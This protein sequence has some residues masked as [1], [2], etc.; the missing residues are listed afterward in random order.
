MA[1][2]LIS[3]LMRRC[4]RGFAIPLS[5]L[6]EQFGA[7]GTFSRFKF[8]IQGHRSHNDLPSFDRS[9]EF[10]AK[11][12]TLDV[13]RRTAGK[14][15][16]GMTSRFKAAA[17]TPTQPDQPLPMPLVNVLADGSLKR[18]AIITPIGSISAFPMSR[19]CAAPNGRVTVLLAYGRHNRANQEARR[20]TIPLKPRRMLKRMSE[21]FGADFRGARLRAGMTHAERTKRARVGRTY[22][23][24][25]APG[26]PRPPRIGLPSLGGIALSMAGLSTSDIRRRQRFGQGTRGGQCGWRALESSASR[27]RSVAVFCSPRKLADAACHAIGGADQA[28]LAGAIFLRELRAFTACGIGKI[29]T[30]EALLFAS[31]APASLAY[32]VAMSRQIAASLPVGSKAAF[33]RQASTRCRYTSGFQL[34]G[35]ARPSKSGG[36]QKPSTA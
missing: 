2:W 30:V 8:E 17:L 11:Q 35:T 5:T 9:L 20:R 34:S 26:A 13:I 10:A 21:E 3:I 27:T 28:S 22:V 16:Q 32:P 15:R 12:P 29:A 18:R 23:S 24:Q 6:F 25:V 36:S 7:E 33:C 19:T 4:R 1:I 14:P 31:S